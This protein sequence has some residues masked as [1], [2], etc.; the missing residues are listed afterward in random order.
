[1]AKLKN[2]PSTQPAQPVQPAQTAPQVQPQ[3]LARITA[4][5]G[6]HMAVAGLHA[7]HYTQ[8]QI[9]SA[10]GAVGI[11]GQAAQTAYAGGVGLFAGQVAYGQAKSAKRAARTAQARAALAY[12][13]QNNITLPTK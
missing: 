1:M 12:V 6:V 13:Q 11:T 7:A 3:R 10:L 5:N 8:A 2:S 4:N 9:L